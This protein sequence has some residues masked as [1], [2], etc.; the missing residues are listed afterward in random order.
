MKLTIRG[1]L[2][3]LVVL[4]VVLMVVLG[5]VARYGMSA[6]RTGLESVVLTARTLRN[7]LE[8]DMMH[9]ALR[10]DVLAALLAE[11]PA[12][13]QK[14][15]ADL[16][17][18]AQH[19]REVIESNQQLA[20][21]KSREAL[22]GIGPALDAYI[23][24]A[25][26][27]V[28]AAERDKAG[29]HRLLPEFLQSFEVLEERLAVVSDRIESGA[30][31]A[32]QQASSVIAR[33]MT[34]GLAA[35]L[36]AI[37]LALTVSGL[38]VRAITTGLKG[39]IAVIA[40]M[41]SGELGRKISI[42]SSDEFGELLTQLR[43][44]DRKLTG[45]VTTV[46]DSAESVGV[47]ARQLSQGNDDLSQRTQEQAA[48]L[49]ESASSMEEMAGTVNQNAENVR[50]ASQLAIGAR[51]Q[52]DRGGAIVGQAVSAMN[53]VSESSRKI[54]DIIGVVDEI[55]FQTNLLALNAAVEAA[56]AAEHGRGFAVVAAEVRHLA[57]RSATAAKEIK[58][59]IQLSV[60][61]VKT[62]AELVGE[63]G[64][65]M[66]EITASVHKLT[67]IV[68]EISAATDE[69]ARS[70][71]EVNRAIAQIDTV[72]QQNAA[73]VEEAAA[74]SKSMEHRTGRLLTEVA[75]FKTSSDDSSAARS[76]HELAT[77]VE[78]SKWDSEPFQKA[79]A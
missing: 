49:E 56:R 43:E 74:S 32:E 45:I 41:T 25:E 48:A 61:R 4:M 21:G 19:F 17:E 2:F 35:L 12:D 70:I 22:S 24:S 27:I 44:L 34:I 13:T 79:A 65:T 60:E 14:V 33:S 78:P 77:R 39:L 36:V 31:D 59:L 71:E 42:E 9:D 28:A 75:F 38:I 18:H 37:A 5:A 47:A 54:A 1:R 58:G 3:C 66:Q 69:Q 55:A 68:G 29:A 76:N 51:D 40:R 67:N 62:G 7:H 20:T 8:G 73:L 26:S 72:T 52:A 57:Q 63:S 53:E 11:S 16:R 64:R 6:A 50:T 10:S 23:K 46:R 15:Q 30:D